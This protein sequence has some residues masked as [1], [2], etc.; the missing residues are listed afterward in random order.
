MVT[1]E[2]ESFTPTAGF[3][4]QIDE[5]QETTATKPVPAKTKHNQGAIFDVFLGGAV[6]FECSKP[7]AVFFRYGRP[8][9]EKGSQ[10][11][12]DWQRQLRGRKVEDTRWVTSV[13]TLKPGLYAPLIVVYDNKFLV[14]HGLW[15][16][17]HQW[18][19]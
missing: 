14:D 15:F 11:D 1:I 7:F 6:R 2:I 12:P 19:T 13:R 5:R 17:V 4:Y 8:D 10:K 16:E 18:G 3:T 9:Q